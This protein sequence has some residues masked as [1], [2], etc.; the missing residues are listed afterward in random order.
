MDK[1]SQSSEYIAIITRPQRAKEHIYNR[2]VIRRVKEPQ[3]ARVTEQ[4]TIL[5]MSLMTC[6]K[7]QKNRNTIVQIRINSIRKN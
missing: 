3:K 1:R 6:T 4:V 5:K 7:M 2:V